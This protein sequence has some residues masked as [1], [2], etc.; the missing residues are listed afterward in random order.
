MSDP[1]N[2]QRF[3]EA[4]A[5][6]YSAALQQLRAGRKTSHW[7]WFIFPQIAGLG[8]SET[9]K[10]F[11]LAGR[12]EAKAYFEHPILGLRLDECTRAVCQ[13]EHRSARQIFGSPDDLKFRSS[14]TLFS[15]AVPEH[16][17][18][19]DALQAYFDGQPDSLTLALLGRP[20]SFEGDEQ[21]S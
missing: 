20:S 8:H 5:A 6:I 21:A 4:Q 17:L 10:R 12:S 7:M 15:Q 11:A 16:A 19:R 1:Y 13:V 9:A 14:M 18:F 2:L 3:V